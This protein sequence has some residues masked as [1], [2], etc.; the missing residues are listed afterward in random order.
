MLV[1]KQL[2]TFFKHAVSLNRVKYDVDQELVINY[3]KL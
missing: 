1:Y 3:A 2:F